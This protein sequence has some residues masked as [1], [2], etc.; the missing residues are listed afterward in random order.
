MVGT[1]RRAVTLVELLVVILIVSILIAMLLPA[2]QMA[3][4][5]ARAAQCRNNLKQLSLA[6]AQ[7]EQHLGHYPAGG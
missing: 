1:A 4:S 6:V 2:V 7:H 5:A 3:R